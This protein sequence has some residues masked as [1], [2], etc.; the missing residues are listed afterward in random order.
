MRASYVFLGGLSSSAASKRISKLSR[1]ELRSAPAGSVD[2][3]F[4]RSSEA[5]E[6]AVSMATLSRALERL[7]LATSCILKSTKSAILEIYAGSSEPVIG[8]SSPSILTIT[9][10]ST[11]QL[12]TQPRSIERG[13]ILLSLYRLESYTQIFAFCQEKTQ[14]S[15]F[16]R[17]SIRS[18]TEASFDLSR[19]DWSL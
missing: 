17:C 4:S 16:S 15:I 6:R 3:D 7:C 2:S 8:Y 10:F 18:S 19:S 11:D 5:S 9:L 14:N 12:R 1:S 13:R